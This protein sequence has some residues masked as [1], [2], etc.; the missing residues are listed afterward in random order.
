MPFYEDLVA[1]TRAERAALLDVAQLRDGLA[2]R[3]TC[4]GY[5][6]Y[7]T[8]AYHHVRHT[9]PLLRMARDLLEHKPLL[10]AA[11]DE[12]IE[13]ENGHE[14][15]VLADIRA[16]GADPQLA[17]SSA[18][19][20]ATAAMVRHVYERVGNVNPV[21][22]FGMVFVLEGTSVALATQGAAAIQASLGLPDSAFTYLTSHGELDQEHLRF[23]ARL[24]NA[25]DDPADQRAIVAMAREMY[26][27]FADLFRSLDL[28]VRDAA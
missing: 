7:L 20:P 6:D 9:V 1:A 4:E 23:F 27:L 10:A 11:L 25:I 19:R 12:Y 15:W 8:Q 22:V 28:G 18:P 2:G 26:G 5:V 3:I 24:M 16:A 14:R 13:E 17:A 21:C